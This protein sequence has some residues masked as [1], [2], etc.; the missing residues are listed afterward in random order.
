MTGT[1]FLRNAVLSKKTR[2]AAVR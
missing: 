1:G 2:L